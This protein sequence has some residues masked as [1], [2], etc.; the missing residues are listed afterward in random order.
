MSR[1][2]GLS[3]VHDGCGGPV[4]AELVVD[5]GLKSGKL[6]VCAMSRADLLSII[7]GAAHALLRLDALGGS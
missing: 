7:G 2:V 6:D 4:S 5:R 3:M 1:Y